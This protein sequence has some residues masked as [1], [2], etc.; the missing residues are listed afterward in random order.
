MLSLRKRA[1]ISGG[2]SALVSLLIGTFLLYSFLNQRA[3]ARFDQS[4]I[5]RHTQIVV[6]LT[7]VSDDPARLS[8]LLF[9]PQYQAPFSGRYWQVTAPDATVFTS[10]SML[11][12]T[13][14]ASQPATSALRVADAANASVEEV[15]VA[16]Q[17]ITLE[18]GSVWTVA[19]A[20]SRSQL[21]KERDEMRQSLVLAFALVAVIGLA[22]VLVQTAAIVRP[23]DRL[24]REVSRRWERDEE[25][26]PWPARSARRWSSRTRPVPA[27]PSAATSSPRRRPTATRC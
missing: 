9:D 1:W 10:A 16:Q 20:E 8:D 19:V 21:N 22:S 11:D 13:L 25:L 2:I 3:L 17:V 14:P 18:D 27:A 23:L 5:E 15:R 26:R 24:R 12:A 6:A 7:S 4:L